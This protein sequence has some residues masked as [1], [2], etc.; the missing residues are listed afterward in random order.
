MAS[1]TNSRRTNGNKDTSAKRGGGRKAS[2]AIEWASPRIQ[3]ALMGTIGR[4]FA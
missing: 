3:V 4:P 1:V 2:P